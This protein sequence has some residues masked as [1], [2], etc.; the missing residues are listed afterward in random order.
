MV[1]TGGVLP[2]RERGFWEKVTSKW[3]KPRWNRGLCRL[4]AIGI[5]L[6]AASVGGCGPRAQIPPLP[7]AIAGALA[8]EDSDALLARQLAPTLYLQRDEVFQLVRAA[9]V[10][11]PMRPV[12]AYHLLWEDDAH[13]AWAPFT[14]AT[15]Q[16]IVWVGYDSTH[17]P[18]DLWTYWHGSILHADWR[19]KG[20]VAVDVQWGKHGSLP[21]G[22]IETS[23]P[24]SKPL[25]FYYALTWFLPDLWLGN[26][27]RRGPWCFCHGYARYREF[28]R[29]ILLGS[30]LDPVVQTSDPHLILG[31]VFGAR[32]SR[33]PAWPW[34]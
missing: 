15:D 11:H 13:G 22:F 6:F 29:P 5:S 34:E 18:T 26:A 12:I 24:R 23:L 7:L 21:R 30:R 20:Q 8:P 3:R 31:Q 10:V 4:R 33:K 27:S 19:G 16:E 2:K 14:V 1:G 25:T 28:T 17:A 9:A 32:Y